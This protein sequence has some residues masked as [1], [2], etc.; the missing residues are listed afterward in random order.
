MTKVKL[1]A[2]VIAL[3]VLSGCTEESKSA[4]M[5]KFTPR[6]M[7]T[8]I[9]SNTPT[10]YNQQRF[11]EVNPEDVLRKLRNGTLDYR[12]GQRTTSKDY[13]AKVAYSE[14][15]YGKGFTEGCRT[16][17]GIIAAGTFRLIP[18]KFDADRLVTDDWYQRGFEDGS[19]FCTYRTDWEMH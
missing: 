12:A 13:L 4:L 18:S 5:R 9:F 10:A 3:L 17:M 14:D 2:W 16:Y 15:S 19:S 1:I 7:R 11:E 8:Q 6:P